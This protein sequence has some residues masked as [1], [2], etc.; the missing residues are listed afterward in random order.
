MRCRRGWG[1]GVYDRAAKHP[2]SLGVAVRAILAE[3]LAASEVAI[4]G[5]SPGPE[6]PRPARDAPCRQRNARERCRPARV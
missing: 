5:S 6:N 2:P 3:I 4:S 1:S